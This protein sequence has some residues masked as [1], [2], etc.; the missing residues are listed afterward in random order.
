MFEAQK[1]AFWKGICK[2]KQQHLRS[3]RRACPP[4]SLLIKHIDRQFILESIFYAYICYIVEIRDTTQNTL[5]HM[6][7]THII[8]LGFQHHFDTCIIAI[9][10][11]EIVSGE[12]L[13]V[14]P[15]SE[16]HI[17]DDSGH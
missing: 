13:I 15:N 1:L 2:K 6:P 4:A 9:D 8:S 5:K 3:R 10:L 14:H 17:P 7:S 11:D 12:L 16:F